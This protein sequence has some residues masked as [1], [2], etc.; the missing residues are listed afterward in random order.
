MLIQRIFRLQQ[1]FFPGFR[2]DRIPLLGRAL[3]KVLSRFQSSTAMVQG[4]R[5]VLDPND[6]LLLSV[7]EV[8]EPVETAFFQRHVEPGH[9][10]VDVG[11]NIGYYTLLF[12][13]AVGA[14]GR[15]YAFEPEP[16]NFAIL[17][18]NVEGNGYRNV[19]LENAAVSDSSGTLD[20]FVNET[21]LGDHQAY[22]AGEGRKRVIVRSVSLDDYFA[23]LA[24]RIDFV[25]MDIQGFEAA[26]LRG[27]KTLL[28]TSPD[29]VLVTELWPKGMVAAGANPEGY[30]H[31]LAQLGFVLFEC[32]ERA[33]RIVPL[34][35]RRVLRE[36]A[37]ERGTGTNLIAC[38]S[39]ERI[40][41]A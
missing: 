11:A 30:L 25:K 18:T 21:N 24:E 26:A 14:S 16:N 12:A 13:R 41:P 5:M 38:R 22:D 8:Y 35:V 15:V 6:S 33:R 27:M 29:V 37:P 31:E 10:V 3:R 9:T 20:L 39:P 28:R 23:D 2:P 36:H 32:D 34:D 1:R 17:R 40:K 4:H 7:R 19:V